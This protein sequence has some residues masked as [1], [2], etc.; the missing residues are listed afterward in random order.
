MNYTAPLKDMLFVMNEL[1]GLDAIAAL[2]GFEDAT[3]D[4]A[5]AVLEENAKFVQD[6]VAPLNRGGDVAPS[7]WKDGVVTTSPGFQ[8]TRSGSSPRPAGR[9]CSTTSSSAARGCRS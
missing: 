9:A 3:R 2:P 4:T 5:Q 8:A 1:A 7:S 6:V